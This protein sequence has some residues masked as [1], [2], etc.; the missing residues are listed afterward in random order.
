MIRQLGTHIRTAFTS[1]CTARALI[2]MFA[3]AIKSRCVKSEYV[4][5]KSFCLRRC[6]PSFATPLASDAA[7]FR[8]P[9]LQ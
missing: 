3:Q 4:Q 2:T 8:L 1:Y 5:P 7:L 6:S 9:F